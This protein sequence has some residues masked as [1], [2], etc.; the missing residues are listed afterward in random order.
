MDWGTYTLLYGILDEAELTKNGSL[1][2]D[3]IALI[4]GHSRD[5]VKVLL[6]PKADT[7]RWVK[8]LN[9]VGDRM[10]KKKFTE[11]DITESFDDLDLAGLDEDLGKDVIKW[12]KMLLKS[13]GL[14]KDT[15]PTK[16][17]TEVTC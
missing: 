17:N 3:K 4:T 10:H 15:E 2:F 13:R 8:L 1:D 16:E 12:V 9:H 5:S 6:A 11:D 7:P 14:L